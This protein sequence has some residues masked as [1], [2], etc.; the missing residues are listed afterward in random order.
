MVRSLERQ[1][2]EAASD[3]KLALENEGFAAECGGVEKLR[4]G[5]F[6]LV[7]QW[8]MTDEPACGV[9]AAERDSHV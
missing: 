4:E 1:V 7:E 2:A 9:L 8:E 6:A 5:L 3:Y